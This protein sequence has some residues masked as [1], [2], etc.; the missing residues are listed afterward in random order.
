MSKYL[1]KTFTILSP[2]LVDDLICMEE[3]AGYSEPLKQDL[4]SYTLR[5]YNYG[6]EPWV[7]NDSEIE[8]LLELGAITIS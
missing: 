7:V 2:E 1:G 8:E 3:R 4:E 6:D 5:A